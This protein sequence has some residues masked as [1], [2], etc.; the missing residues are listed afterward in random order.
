MKPRPIAGADGCAGGWVAVL[1]RPGRAVEAAVFAAFA[2]LAEA[3]GVD[4]L[5][6][7]DMPIGLPDQIGPGGRGPERLIRPLLGPRQSSVFSIPSRAAVYAE[8]GPFASEVESY[9]AHRRASAVALATSDPPRKISIQAFG[10]FDKIKE[11]DRLLAKRPELRARV[12]ESHP[13]LAFWSLN[14]GRAM[15]LPKKVKGRVN[16]AG[17]AERRALLRRCGL[18][19]LVVDGAPPRGAARYD[20]LDACAMFVVAQR[21]AAGATTPYPDPPLVDGEGIPIAIWAAAIA[22]GRV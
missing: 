15:S 19:G 10:L 2:D 13:E 18:S 12:I 16:A 8:P 11:I 9:A 3:V 5:I 1:Q 20:L 14:G 7:V 22:D 17:M 6:A 21:H 4:G